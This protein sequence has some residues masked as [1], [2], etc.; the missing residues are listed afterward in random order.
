[1]RLVLSTL[2]RAEEDVPR[3]ADRK[4]GKVQSTHNNFHQPIQIF[5]FKIYALFKV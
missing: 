1:M 4:P 2:L 5:E 3:S